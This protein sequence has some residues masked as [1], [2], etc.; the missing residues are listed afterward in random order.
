MDDEDKYRVEEPRKSEERTG[1]LR[2]LPEA[3]RKT[4]SSGEAIT[5]FLG[6]TMRERV[7][8]YLVLF[9]IPACAALIDTYIFSQIVIDALPDTAIYVFMIPMIAAIPVGLTAG[10][11]SDAM[12]GSLLTTVFYLVFFT[13]FLVTPA[14]LA[15]EA[16]FGSFFITGF[17][18]SAGYVYIVI[19]ANL[20]G[21][22][23]GIIMREF[24]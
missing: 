17:V 3:P 14:W 20:L 21:A 23:F 7:R 22:L 2:P 11:T 4:S 9:M 18:V 15:P 5:T 8:D 13:L 16:D 6:I 19:M 1:F 24:L 10:K 12:I